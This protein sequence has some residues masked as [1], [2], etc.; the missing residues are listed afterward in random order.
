MAAIRIVAASRRMA[1]FS[2]RVFVGL[3]ISVI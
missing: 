1:I 2:E 3:A